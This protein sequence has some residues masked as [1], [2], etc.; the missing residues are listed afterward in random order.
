MHRR[1]G[2]TRIWRRDI[3]Q[4]LAA[5]D[6][7]ISL[8]ATTGEVVALASLGAVWGEPGVVDLG[9]HVADDVH[10]QGIGTALTRH[11][12]DHGHRH[13][14]HTLSAYTELANTPALGLLRALGPT[15][16]TRQA[17]QV[18]VRLPLRHITTPSMPS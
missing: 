4:L 3:E 11:A 9:L 7:W 17:G 5:C 15:Q 10:R 8:D 2:R 13:G 12:A 1:W 16:E 18:E 6:C 14:A